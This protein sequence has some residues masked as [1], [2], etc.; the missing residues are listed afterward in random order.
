MVFLPATEAN[1]NKVAVIRSCAFVA[2][3]IGSRSSATIA[4]VGGTRRA[5]N[6]SVSI[7]AK[8]ERTAVTPPLLP[9]IVATGGDTQQ[10]T[11]RGNWI[12]GR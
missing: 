4:C 1:T 12:V 8:T 5:K 11:H 3:Y 10:P 2:L 7:Y 6:A 9:R